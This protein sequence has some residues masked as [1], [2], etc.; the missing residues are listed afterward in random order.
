MN[1]DAMDAVPYIT[2]L[3]NLIYNI[4]VSQSPMIVRSINNLKK[5]LYI[6]WPS[7]LYNIFGFEG[8]T[9]YR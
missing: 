3:Y 7:D 2:K 9:H 4:D 5:A 8:L 6:S 1:G